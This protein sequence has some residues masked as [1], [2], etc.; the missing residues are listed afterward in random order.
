MAQRIFPLLTVVRRL[1]PTSG[2]MSRGLCGPPNWAASASRLGSIIDMLGPDQMLGNLVSGDTLHTLQ[3]RKYL[4]TNGQS[5]LQIA[6]HLHRCA[7][8][9]CHDIVITRISICK[10]LDI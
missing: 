3:N 4:Q 6:A 5:S 10:Y 1:A 7:A 9:S 8:I 2:L